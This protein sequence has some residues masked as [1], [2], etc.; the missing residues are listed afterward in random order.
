MP[1]DVRKGI[2]PPYDFFCTVR[3]VVLNAAFLTHWHEMAL[4]LTKE[5]ACPKQVPSR[6][7]M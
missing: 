2:T 5:Y 6:V 7:P 3:R 4:W 1:V